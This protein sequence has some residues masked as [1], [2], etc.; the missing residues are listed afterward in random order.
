M[1]L[2]TETFIGAIFDNDMRTFLVDKPDQNFLLLQN[3]L[4]CIHSY[5]SPHCI[6]TSPWLHWRTHFLKLHTDTLLSAK[7][8]NDMSS[9][10][11]RQP[12]SIFRSVS[13]STRMHSLLLKSSFHLNKYLTGLKNTFRETAYRDVYKREIWQRHEYFSR[14]Q[15][16]SIIP[17]LSLSTRMHTLLL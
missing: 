9:F 7:F 6:W 16:R 17:S 15:P 4:R 2:H 3:L 13:A 8:D 14:R 12:R 5:S 10:F 11:R 1:K